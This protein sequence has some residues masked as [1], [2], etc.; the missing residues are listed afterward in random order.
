[1]PRLEDIVDTERL[2]HAADGVVA[3][4]RNEFM[5]RLIVMRKD[6]PKSFA[7]MSS[8]AK[9]ALAYYEGAKRRAEILAT[10]K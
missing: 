4:Q 2:Q 5:E 8:A 3:F 1:M 9:L 10:N 7:S 6:R